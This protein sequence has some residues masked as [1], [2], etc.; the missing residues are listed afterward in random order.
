M[1]TAYIDRSGAHP[2]RTV[3]VASKNPDYGLNRSSDGSITGCLARTCRFGH[4]MSTQHGVEATS[5]P[6]SFT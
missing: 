1:P 5:R 3:S 6:H 4:R 2:N